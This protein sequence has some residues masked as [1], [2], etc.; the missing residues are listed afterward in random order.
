M[1][2]SLTK[3]VLSAAIM[4]SGTTAALAAVHGVPMQNHSTSGPMAHGPVATG[5]TSVAPSKGAVA[6]QSSIPLTPLPD[7]LC[8]QGLTVI[9]EDTPMSK[10]VVPT[11]P[12]MPGQ[13]AP[14]GTTSTLPNG[15]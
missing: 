11:G 12:G 5:G 14:I 1:N 2:W 3:L 4:F 7:G 9:P 6:S 13:P 15:Q 10:P 8:C